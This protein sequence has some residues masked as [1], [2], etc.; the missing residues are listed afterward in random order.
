M[1][2]FLWGAGRGCTWC[3]KLLHKYHIPINAIIDNKCS[4]LAELGEA[5]NI[6]P[7]VTYGQV[8][9]EYSECIIVI[10]ALA[11]RREITEQIEA[12]DINSHVFVFDALLEVL[13]NVTPADRRR[14]YLK[15]Q[16][17]LNWLYGR[18]ADRFSRETLVQVVKGALTSS[19]DCYE[20]IARKPQY[21]PSFILDK[22]NDNEVFVDAGAY[23]GDTIMEFIDIV[24]DKYK[25]IYGFEPDKSNYLVCEK[26]AA[27]KEFNFFDMGLEKKRILYFSAMNLTVHKWMKEHIS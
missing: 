3:I 24:E 12:S 26:I 13:Q 6:I 22:M 11:Y 19:C 25:L 21:F 20:E 7:L 17:H 14:F 10:A 5:V 18:L 2:V 4:E 23:I 9:K 15:S 1:P 27:T 8:L 16:S